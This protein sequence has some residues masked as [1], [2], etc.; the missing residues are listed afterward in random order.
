MSVRQWR[1]RPSL[2]LDLFYCVA[3]EIYLQYHHFSLLNPH[4]PPLSEP[5]PIPSGCPSSSLEAIATPEVCWVASAA[6]PPTPSYKPPSLTALSRTAPLLYLP[7]VFFL[8][9][10]E[11]ILFFWYVVLFIYFLLPKGELSR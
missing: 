3:F 1:M 2:C 10:T 11:D 6:L 5:W 8:A 7:R 4:F 9:L